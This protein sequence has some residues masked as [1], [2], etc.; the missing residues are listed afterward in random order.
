MNVSLNGTEVAKLQ[1]FN[2]F[3]LT[4]Q[5]RSYLTLNSDIDPDHNIYSQFLHCI[6]DCDYNYGRTF[7]KLNGNHT[8]KEN[9]LF[10]A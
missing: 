6:D 10:V 3:S 7:E 8:G 1:N 4:D 5:G 2:P 9:K